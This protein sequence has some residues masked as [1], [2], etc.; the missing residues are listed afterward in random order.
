[1][2]SLTSE[3]DS[4]TFAGE[5][6]QRHLTYYF[7]SLTSDMNHVS[8]SPPV[9]AA[10]QGMT[11]ITIREVRVHYFF[12]SWLSVNSLSSPVNGYSVERF[13]GYSVERFNGY[14]VER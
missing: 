3:S 2:A 5:E 14:S 12:A 13:N 11:D 8:Q 9:P 7:F 4:T 10:P 1:M 6:M